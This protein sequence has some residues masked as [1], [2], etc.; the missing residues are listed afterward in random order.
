MQS[1]NSNPIDELR[2]SLR[3][4]N[5]LK[6]EGIQTV[7]E[8]VERSAKWIVATPGLGRK[9]LEEIRRKLARPLV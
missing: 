7:G 2:L 6:R 8:L 3:V 5:A 1:R 4:V 9:S